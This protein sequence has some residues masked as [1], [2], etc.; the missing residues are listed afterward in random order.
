MRAAADAVLAAPVLVGGSLFAYAAAFGVRAL[1]WRSVQPAIGLGHAWSAVHVGLLANHVLPLRMGEV[2]RVASAV[3][4][5]R[6]P[7]AETTA[8]TVTLRFGDLLVLFVM[9]LATVPVAIDAILG[10]WATA[11]TVT[12]LTAGIVLA[13]KWRARQPETAAVTSM[14]MLWLAVAVACSWLL[15]SV[16]LYTVA[17]TV[18]LPV[19]PVQAV[20]VTAVTI[21]AQVVAITPGGFGTYE[22]AGTTALVAL[23]LPAAPALA[24]MLTTHAVKT[25]YSLVLGAV[26]VAV[27]AP[28][29][30]GR[31]RLPRDLPARPQPQPLTPQAPVVVMLPVHNEAATIGSVLGRIPQQVHGR[32]VQTIVVDDGSGDDSAAI[33]QAAGAH[34]IRHDVNRGLGAAVRTALQAAAHRGAAAGVYLD[35]DGEYRP[36]DI[37][38]VAGPV[39]RQEADY[40]VG[41]RFRGRI[42]HMRAH[43]RLGNQLLTAWVRWMTRNP[44]LTDGQSGFR[45]FSPAALAQAEI[46]HDYNYAQVLTLDLL[47]K[48]FRYAE[49]PI[50]YSF[51]TSGTSFI[52]LGRY[53]RRVV[54]AVHEQLNLPGP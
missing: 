47:A 44:G 52:R 26:A 35:A 53:L 5:A 34:V 48:G 25:V 37:G 50:G 51:R 14:K 27:P 31:L 40:V 39:L 11:A 2:M 20:G 17:H 3:R 22:A 36:E 41:S 33:A 18:G 1:A 16:V 23:G 15:E 30:W 6:I 29:I 21:L 24:V 4:R 28:A 42:E 49:V 12:A 8:V 43:R 7:V 45:A 32:P 13:L 54:P 38:A 46:I 19:S 9:A 10:R